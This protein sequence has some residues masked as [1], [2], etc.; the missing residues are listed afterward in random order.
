MQAGN[1]IRVQFYMMG[2]PS[3]QEDFTVEEFRFC[4]GVFLSDDHRK[5]G[6][7]TPL[8]EMYEPGPY[9]RQEYISNYGEYT[10][11]MVPAWM[12]LPPETNLNQGESL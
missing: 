6:H 8:C 12:D 11:D 10:T 5:A 1:R 4:L 3:Y 2:H 9:S 7:F